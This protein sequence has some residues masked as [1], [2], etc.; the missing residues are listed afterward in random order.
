MSQ[1]KEYSNWFYGIEYLYMDQG[2]LSVCRQTE[3]KNSCWSPAKDKINSDQCQIIPV[4]SQV[5]V[6]NKWVPAYN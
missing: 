1:V 5:F 6:P 3:M 4:C 2:Y